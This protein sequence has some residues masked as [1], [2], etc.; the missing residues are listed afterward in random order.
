MFSLFTNGL[1]EQID[2]CGDSFIRVLFSGKTGRRSI[3]LINLEIPVLVQSLKSSNI[4][5][6]KYLDGRLFKCCPS[7]AANP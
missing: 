6:G 2:R 5:V 7:V 1:I 4:E 3:W